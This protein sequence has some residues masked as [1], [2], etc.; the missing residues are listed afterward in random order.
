MNEYGANHGRWAWVCM[1][2]FLVMGLV[3][4]LG[5]AVVILGLVF[6][7]QVLSVIRHPSSMRLS[8]QSSILITTFLLTL[9]VHIVYNITFVQHQGRYLFPALL[10]I[11]VGVAVGLD[12]W[13]H[14]PV[15][16]RYTFL[17]GL[18]PLG[19]GLGLLTLNVWVLSRIIPHLA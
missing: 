17:P 19:L 1:P 10:P 2:F 11:G 9:A 18:I 3:L 8:P 5:T 13:L 6:N 4:W 16:K 14:L 7:R 15:L 12:A